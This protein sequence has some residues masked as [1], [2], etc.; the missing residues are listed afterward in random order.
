MQSPE[1]IL[2][3]RSILV[4]TDGS[5]LAGS[6]LAYACRLAKVFDA[7]I[8]VCH[9]IDYL[10]LPGYLAK[11]PE[12]APRLLVEDGEAVLDAARAIACEH[13]LEIIGH[14]V[15]GAVAPAIVRLATT[16]GVDMIVMGTHGRSG[17]G[18]FVLGSVAADV[19]RS[20]PVPVVV[21]PASVREIGG[22]A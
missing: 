14:L 5:D 9:G 16:I 20:A 2:A 13:E 3:I 4:P 12:S 17:V 8:H 10:S 11:G 6:A 7:T 15:R 22:S 21:V 1:T 18:R 19:L